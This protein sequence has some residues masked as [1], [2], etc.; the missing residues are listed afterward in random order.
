VN[1]G[2]IWEEDITQDYGFELGLWNNQIS[3]SG[4]YYHKYTKGML[5]NIPIP[6]SVGAGSSIT[7][8]AGEILNKGFEFELFY[9]DN[10]GDVAFDAILTLSRNKNE[11][12]NIGEGNILRSGEPIWDTENVLWSQAGGSFGDFYLV[13]TDGIFQDQDQV[14][15]HSWTDPETAEKKLIQPNAE[16]GD[17]RYVDFNDDGQIDD[18]DRQYY[19]NTFPKFE[20]GINLNAGYMGFDLNLYFY[21][22]YGNYVYNGGRYMFEGMTG[23]WN[24]STAVINRWTPENPSTT[25]PRAIWNDPNKNTKPATDR[26]LEDGSFLKLKLLTLGYTLPSRLTSRIG[27]SNLRI[28]L[29]G[30]NLFTLTRYSG[31]DPEIGRDGYLSRGIDRGTTPGLRTYLIGIQLG[32]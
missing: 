24:Q 10:F 17:I 8:N 14:A 1:P 9:K 30:Q 29:S 15:A 4:N 19:G 20:G 6:N 12:I 22:N 13:E 11:I 3:L 32:I 16:P 2:L 18:N 23:I 5:L 26:F 7:D 25:M 27:V 21:G 28:Y 31:L